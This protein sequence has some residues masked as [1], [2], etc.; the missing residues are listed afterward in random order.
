MAEVFCLYSTVD[1]RPRYI[2]TTAGSSEKTY[3][4]HVTLALEKESGE[5][6]DWMR[7]SWRKKSDIGF[8]V[9]QTGIKAKEL[10]FYEKYWIAQFP[11]LINGRGSGKRVK[12]ASDI[13]RQITIAIKAKLVVDLAQ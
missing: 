2:A 11:R 4:K 5:V 7:E 8:Y 10:E 9:L 1:G 12:K 3:K 13:A 6:F